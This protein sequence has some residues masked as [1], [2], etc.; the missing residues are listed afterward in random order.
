MTL[1]S[2][3]ARAAQIAL[4][5]R[6]FVGLHAEVAPY[7]HEFFSAA[8]RWPPASGRGIALAPFVP[9]W[10]PWLGPKVW[11]SVDAYYRQQLAGP[12]LASW[13]EAEA[14]RPEPLGASR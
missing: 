1:E 8:T 9:R 10:V 4:A 13:E 5:E 6:A 3:G 14:S 7:F 2:W 11:N 12:F